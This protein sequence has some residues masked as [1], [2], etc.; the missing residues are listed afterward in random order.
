MLFQTRM[1]Y[2]LGEILYNVLIRAISRAVTMSLE[3]VFLSHL[4]IIH[5]V[6]EFNSWSEPVDLL[7][8][9]SDRF[10]GQSNNSNVFY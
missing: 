10:C 7:T 5:W 8:N 9:H 3:L 1:A 6:I 2:F 4:Y